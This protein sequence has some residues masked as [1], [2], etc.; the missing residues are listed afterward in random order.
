MDAGWKPVL[1]E[2][3]RIEVDRV[4]AELANDARTLVVRATRGELNDLGLFS[5]YAGALLLLEYLAC[6]NQDADLADTVVEGLAPLLDRIGSIGHRCDLG[7]GWI[8]VAWLLTHVHETRA[9]VDRDLVELLGRGALPLTESW[10]STFELVYGLVGVGVYHL[11][12]AA[13]GFEAEEALAAVVNR[14]Q[15][16]AVTRRDGVTWWSIAPPAMRDRWPEGYCNLGVAHG[17]PGVFAFATFAD[18]LGVPGAGRIAEAALE[19]CHRHR[20]ADG[21]GSVY[22]YH[23]DEA[24]L[25]WMMPTGLAWCY[26]DVGIAAILIAA[27]RV[28]D[29]AEWMAE[30]LTLA[31]RCA[32]KL[33]G[34]CGP[35]DGLCHGAAGVAHLFNRMYQATGAPELKRSAQVLFRRLLNSR[36]PSAGW[37]GFRAHDGKGEL[38]VGGDHRLLNGGAGVGLALISACSHM[39]PAWDQLLLLSPPASRAPHQERARHR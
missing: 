32:A 7:E 37:G 24:G 27:G 16:L 23:Y 11:Q 4:L 18:R 33:E 31:L 29:S 10:R 5:G 39:P 3:D 25:D 19:A 26:G 12:R 30:G 1:D 20:L 22:P 35:D 17:V 9:A 6:L 21:A 13:L 34:W 28:H 2:T 8:G 14:L 36:E 15:D 38:I